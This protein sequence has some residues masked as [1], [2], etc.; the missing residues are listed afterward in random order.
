MGFV[1]YREEGGLLL[2]VPVFLQI[3]KLTCWID[4]N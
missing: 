4:I 2:L 3:I 1:A